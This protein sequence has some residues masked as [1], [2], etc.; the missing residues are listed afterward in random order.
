[1]G[2]ICERANKC[3][4]ASGTSLE[5]PEN[6][7][8]CPETLGFGCC[9]NGMGCGKDQCFQKAPS[10][11]T[12]TRTTTSDDVT[13]TTTITTTSTPVTPG[14]G[15]ELMSTAYKIYPTA[16][17]KTMPI[18][19]NGGDG[20]GLK[21]SQLGGIVGGA[22]AIL[23]I[24]I[25]AAFFVI[26]QL[27]KVDRNRAAK[28]AGGPSSRGSRSR[29][30]MKQVNQPNSSDTDAASVVV[31]FLH[32]SRN[33]SQQTAESDAESPA[34]Y[35]DAALKNPA[36]NHGYQSVATGQ[37]RGHQNGV[38][39]SQTDRFNSAASQRSIPRRPIEQST[40]AG[41]RTSADSHRT[42]ATSSRQRSNTNETSTSDV[43][44]TVLELEA[45]TVFVE[46]PVNPPADPS[47]PPL[48]HQR[49]RS[50]GSTHSR[51]D[52]L[53]G[54]G[55]PQLDVVSELAETQW[56]HGGYYGPATHAG[57]TG[58]DYPVPKSP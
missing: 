14:A 33:S 57:Q 44:S 7:F 54:L 4:P 16:I 18:P 36:P 43:P 29:P 45:S 5:C 47:R 2:L 53:A 42:N 32:H 19:S 3:N 58:A 28:E 13:I 27:R 56:Y 40:P 34:P 17:N 46:L 24:I 31:P 38:D 6:F 8:L 15:A 12:Y 39:S 49:N 10:T 1:V 41:R 11:Y 25:V 20:G 26:R 52:S 50:G 21:K 48:I 51:N 22:V 37:E 55:T 30:N 23:V 35:H 9:A